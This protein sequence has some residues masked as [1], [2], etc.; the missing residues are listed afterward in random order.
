M[1]EIKNKDDL[2]IGQWAFICCEMDIYK[3]ETEEDIQDIA[4]DWDDRDAGDTHFGRRVFETRE[5]ALKAAS[6]PVDGGGNG[7]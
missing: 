6:Q 5:D 4:D 7:E 3:V 1:S 2:R